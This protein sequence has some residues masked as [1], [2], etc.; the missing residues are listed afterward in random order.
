MTANQINYAK[1]REDVRHNRVSEIHE[2]RKIGISERAQTETER[3]NREGETINWFQSREAARHNVVSESQFSDQLAET[4]RANQAREYETHRSNVAQESE[5]R[6]SHLA[7]EALQGSSLAE[8]IRHNRIGETET[9]RH[10]LASESYNLSQLTQRRRELEESARHNREQE[11]I[12][13][14]DASAAQIRAQASMR[15]AEAAIQQA[16][17]RHLEVQNTYDM[18]SR[19]LVETSRHNREI[20]QQQRAQTRARNREVYVS[21]MQQ[22]DNREM[23]GYRKAQAI[24]STARDAS[25]AIAGFGKIIGG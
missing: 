24:A 8:S 9:A 22:N 25:I 3:H 1:H 7:N 17:T 19:Q 13:W 16:G 18:Q 4:R 6:R 11:R 12:S 5:A 14:Y 23:L 20:E 21:E 15:S 10:N 2:H